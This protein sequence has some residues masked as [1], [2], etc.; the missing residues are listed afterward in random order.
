MTS[1]WKWRCGSEWLFDVFVSV[2]EADFLECFFYKFFW[3]SSH[4]EVLFKVFHCFQE[5][6]FAGI[7]T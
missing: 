2:T 4:E 3:V 5:K 1:R 6:V 7:W